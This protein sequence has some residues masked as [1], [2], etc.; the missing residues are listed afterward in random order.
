MVFTNDHA[1]Q[2]FKRATVFLHVL[3]IEACFVDEA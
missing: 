2:R 1:I 3:L